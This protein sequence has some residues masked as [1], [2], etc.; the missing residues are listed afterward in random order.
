[1]TT[2]R[3]SWTSLFLGMGYLIGTRSPDPSTKV[4]AV[5]A[6]QDNVILST[7]Y[8]GWCRNLEEIPLDSDK[9]K[10][11]EKYFHFEH[12]ERNAI[13]NAARTGIS[14]VNSILYVPWLSCIECA[15]AIVQVG[16]SQVVVHKEGQENYEK[17]Y[18]YKHA[19][20]EEHKRVKELFL[21]TQTDL[22]FWSGEVTKPFCY[23]NGKQIW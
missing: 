10:K 11:P 15:R 2:E 21:Q 5:I 3:S 12:A 8:N 14:L 7:G 18:N 6:S 4:G 23:F 13:Y 17:A 19:Y 20:T 1:M 9:L 22:I 16:I